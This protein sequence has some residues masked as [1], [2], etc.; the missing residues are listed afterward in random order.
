MYVEL[1]ERY[2]ILV[3]F[4]SVKMVVYSLLLCVR[5]LNFTI[6]RTAF[7]ASTPAMSYSILSSIT[8]SGSKL[9]PIIRVTT[10]TVIIFFV[11]YPL[12]T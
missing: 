4:I 6:N 1:Q 7:L 9:Q 8:I 10:S 5:V 11:Y 2:V 12:R 3:C